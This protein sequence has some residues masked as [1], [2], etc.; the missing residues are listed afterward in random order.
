MRTIAC[1]TLLSAGF[2]T[3]D[4]RQT[5]RL[6]LRLMTPIP[7]MGSCSSQRCILPFR[8]QDQKTSHQERVSKCDSLASRNYQGRGKNLIYS[9]GSYSNSVSLLLIPLIPENQPVG[10]LII[11]TNSLKLFANLQLLIGGPK[12]YAAWKKSIPQ[13]RAALKSPSVSPTKTGL[14]TLF[15]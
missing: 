7:M 14:I 12:P 8:S 6:S 11:S 9:E 15:L 1:Q 10:P 13:S 4:K 5:K 3:H 2:I